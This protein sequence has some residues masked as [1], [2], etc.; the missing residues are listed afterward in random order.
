MR[1]FRRRFWSIRSARALQTTRR[2]R[3]FGISY[4]RPI[5]I[6]SCARVNR[7]S[8]LGGTIQQRSSGSLGLVLYA[9]DLIFLRK[10][11]RACADEYQDSGRD[12]AGWRNL[13]SHGLG[14]S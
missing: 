14:L 6:L 11:I 4:G 9:R 8:G 2:A 1:I 10:P 5:S 7:F 3:A 13:V 12:Y